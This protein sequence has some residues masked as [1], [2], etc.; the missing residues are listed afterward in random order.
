MAFI[1]RF[2]LHCC[3]VSLELLN[4]TRSWSG[5]QC[6]RGTEDR[7]YQFSARKSACIVMLRSVSISVSGSTAKLFLR[8]AVQ[9]YHLLALYFLVLDCSLSSVCTT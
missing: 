1:S 5:V 4:S 8:P 7:V 9:R 6:R 2:M 3:R